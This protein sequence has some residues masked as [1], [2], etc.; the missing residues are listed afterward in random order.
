MVHKMSKFALLLIVSMS[1]LGCSN[2]KKSFDGSKRQ[3]TGQCINSIAKAGMGG[4]VLC[5][6]V[7]PKFPKAAILNGIQGFVILTYSVDK[8]GT[9]VDIDIIKSEPLGIFDRAAIQAFS[10]YRYSPKHIDNTPVRDDNLTFTMD[11]KYE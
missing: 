1:M 5:S 7:F 3:S 2:A 11:F 9:P 6:F 4:A 10:Q 8:Y